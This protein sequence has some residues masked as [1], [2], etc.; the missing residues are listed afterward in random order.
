MFLKHISHL[1]AN[2]DRINLSDIP[3]IKPNLSLAGT[4]I[5]GQQISQC[6]FA[7]TR[8]TYNR[9]QLPNGQLKIDM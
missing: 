3:T 5:T 9:H 1:M 4:K 2:S 6:G 7:R 8:W